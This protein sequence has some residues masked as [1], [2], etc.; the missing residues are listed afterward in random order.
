MWKIL[1][2]LGVV[3]HQGLALF[4]VLSYAALTCAS[5]LRHA[6]RSHCRHLSLRATRLLR[7]AAK[8]SLIVSKDGISAMER[9]M[10]AVKGATYVEAVDCILSARDVA[11]FTGVSID[12]MRSYLNSQ[13][14]GAYAELMDN[15]NAPSHPPQTTSTAA[16]P[17]SSISVPKATQAF[18]W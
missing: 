2:N 7:D 14:D 13:M 17:P 16:L 9:Y 4:V 3:G 18:V 5:I 1:S 10:E 11:R 12:E 6:E 15:R 8:S